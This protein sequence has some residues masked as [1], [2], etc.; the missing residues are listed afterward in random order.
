M[1]TVVVALFDKKAKVFKTPFYVPQVEIAVRSL[2]GAV[3]GPDRTD[4]T[5]F[6][7]DFALYQIAT[8]DDE[9]A[10][11]DCPPQPLFVAEAIQFKKPSVPQLGLINAA[12]TI[13]P[14][15]RGNV[16]KQKS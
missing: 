13:T 6:P 1:K 7:E 4:L 14:R 8:Y 10:K 12:E 9:T 15:E 11:F 5:D 3:N 16:Q 2:V